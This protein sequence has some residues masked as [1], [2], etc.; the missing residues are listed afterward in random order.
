MTR[1]VVIVLDSGGIGVRSDAAIDGEP[2]GVSTIGNVAAHI[3]GVTF[4]NF[5]RRGPRFFADVRGAAATRERAAYVTRL[6]DISKGKDTISSGHWNVAGIHTDVRFP[7]YRDGFPPALRAGFVAACGV[8]PPGNG[9]ASGSASTDCCAPANQCD[10]AH[11]AL[12]KDHDNSD[13][14]GGN[15]SARVA[16]NER[17]DGTYVRPPC[18]PDLTNGNDI[19]HD[20]AHAGCAPPV[21]AEGT[22][23]SVT[24]AA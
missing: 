12:G 13:G 16:R 2:S 8:A 17:S 24:V 23:A 5:E 6:A 14:H 4:A 3:G 22:L 18:S 9:W 11:E 1:C 21:D 19:A 15:T 10:D 7:T 20:T